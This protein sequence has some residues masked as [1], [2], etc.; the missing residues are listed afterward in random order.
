MAAFCR[1]CSHVA[2]DLGSQISFSN[3]NKTMRTRLKK[4]ETRRRASQRTRRHWF[5]NAVIF[6]NCSR[7][8]WH[9]SSI[10][11]WWHIPFVVVANGG[12]DGKA[13]DLIGFPFFPPLYV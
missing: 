4:Q 3:N 9:R 1:R 13:C 8:A 10:S 11:S 6:L 7:M 5:C 12:A 2:G